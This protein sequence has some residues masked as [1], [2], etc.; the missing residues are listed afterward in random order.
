ML[1]VNMSVIDYNW[2]EKNLWLIQLC[3]FNLLTGFWSKERDSKCIGLTPSLSPSFHH[4]YWLTRQ[5][6]GWSATIYMY[7]YT[8]TIY[9]LI[10]SVRTYTIAES[11]RTCQE[12]ANFWWKWKFLWKWMTL[13]SSPLQT[14]QF[15]IINHYWEAFAEL[16]PLWKKKREGVHIRACAL[17][18]MNMI[19]RFLVIIIFYVSVVV[20]PGR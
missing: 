16:Y 6:F 12:L 9:V 10:S 20:W 14:D 2:K 8:H 11:N 17:I 15:I 13:V 4:K 7:L 18:R 1:V 3:S 19:T 5:T